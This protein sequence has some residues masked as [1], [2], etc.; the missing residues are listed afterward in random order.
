ML[1][2]KKK[3]DTW[4]MCMDYRALNVVTVKYKYPIPVVDGLLD[5]IHGS[6]IYTKLDLRSRYHQIMMHS[7]DVNKTTF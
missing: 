7:D 3:D 5:E 2:V 1:L 4:Q 6:V